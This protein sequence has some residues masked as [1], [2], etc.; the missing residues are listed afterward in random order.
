[1]PENVR[2]ALAVTRMFLE[3][4]GDGL[5]GMPYAELDESGKLRIVPNAFPTV[6]SYSEM[7]ENTSTVLAPLAQKDY[8]LRQSSSIRC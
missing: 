1:M 8:H 5:C 2:R 3:P 6:E 7:L 4:D